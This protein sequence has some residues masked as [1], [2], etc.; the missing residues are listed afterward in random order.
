MRRVKLDWYRRGR[1]SDPVTIRA[2]LL[3]VYAG[4][5]GVTNVSA[6][7]IVPRGLRG[8]ADVS[9]TISAAFYLGDL[10]V[11]HDDRVYVVLQVQPAPAFNRL[12]LAEIYRPIPDEFST[13]QDVEAFWEAEAIGAWVI[14]AGTGILS[15]L[16]VTGTT[17]LAVPWLHQPVKGDFDVYCQMRHNAT[18][19]S[20]GTAY[21][22]IKAGNSADDACAVVG[23]SQTSTAVNFFHREI[24]GIN[25][26]SVNGANK[27][28]PG[29]WAYVRLARSGF[30]FSAYYST[31][32]AAPL[33]DADW[34]ELTGANVCLT[35]DD[36]LVGLGSYTDSG[37]D[38]PE[39][40]WEFFRNWFPAGR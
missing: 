13:G 3:D 4:A 34:V 30:R 16:R 39:P 27:H 1:G 6:E 2:A 19:A 15:T 7:R 29:V 26:D 22:F 31:T 33:R 37:T 20:A 35:G 14:D 21:S 28:E 25:D 36:L 11:D 18:V 23:L 17:P 12:S 10:L 5:V 40:E 24:F 38:D 8:H 9:R 32:V